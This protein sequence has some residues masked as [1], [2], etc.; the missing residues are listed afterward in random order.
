[1]W[2]NKQPIHTLNI[3]PIIINSHYTVY[4]SCSVIANWLNSFKNRNDNPLTKIDTTVKNSALTPECISLCAN[5]ILS[6]NWE[7]NDNIKKS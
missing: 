3:F 5:Q 4:K 6:I 1:M 7:Q 2:A